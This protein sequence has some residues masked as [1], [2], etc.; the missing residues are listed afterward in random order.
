[1]DIIRLAFGLR[2]AVA[3]FAGKAKRFYYSVML[4][5]HACS[6]CGDSLAMV[7]E[8][9]CRCRSC[10]H[11]FDATVAF[12]RCTACGGVPV[13]RIRRYSCKQCGA[14]VPSRFLFDGLV[15]D[16]DY[17]RTRMLEAR[18]RS[19]VRLE[20][21]RKMLAATR[22]L[23]LEHVG[24][25]QLHAVPGLEEALNGLVGGLELGHL[26]QLESGFD[27]QRYQRHI[28]AHLGMIPVSLR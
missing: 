24:P 2:D 15:F 25:I 1:M 9:R 18:Q 14:D 10:N 5:G 4:L 13:L 11:I 19:Q 27:L 28:Q 17:F 22:S 26:P 6:R 21:V 16:A 7:G 12:Q 20:T 3:G 8:G 23:P